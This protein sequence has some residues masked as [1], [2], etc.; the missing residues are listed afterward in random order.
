[1]GRIFSSVLWPGSV[2]FNHRTCVHKAKAVFLK[3]PIS[4]LMCVCDLREQPAQRINKTITS[5]GQTKWRSIKISFLLLLLLQPLCTSSPP[6]PLL[7]SSSSFPNP[8]VNEFVCPRSVLGFEFFCQRLSRMSKI[9]IMSG[10]RW[11]RVVVAVYRQHKSTKRPTYMNKKKSY[12]STNGP[13]ILQLFHSYLL[14]YKFI[15]C[16][17]DM[18]ELRVW[19]T[20]W[21]TESCIWRSLSF[22]QETIRQRHKKTTIWARDDTY[23]SI[24][25]IKNQ[26]SPKRR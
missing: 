1:M 14:Y 18:S 19:R 16:F 22:L 11:F 6:L 26:S 8:F 13:I 12:S 9:S 25:R 5:L 10:F 3:T 7:P 17:Y 21:E 24:R 20:I 2:V 23:P 15:V 4:G